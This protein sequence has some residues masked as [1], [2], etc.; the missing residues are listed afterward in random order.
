[1]STRERAVLQN[2][3]NEKHGS[4]GAKTRRGRLPLTDVSLLPTSL[5]A[6]LLG[7]LPTIALSRIA[8]RPLGSDSTSGGLARLHADAAAA[9]HGDLLRLRFGLLGDLHGED[10]VTQIGFDE[11][12]R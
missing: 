9:L 2:S 6:L 1:M 10:P 8:L 3:T 12:T 11:I 5:P 7:Y 4:E